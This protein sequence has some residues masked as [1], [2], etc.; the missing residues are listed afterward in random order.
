[1][2]SMDVETISKLC[3][4]LVHSKQ[5]IIFHSKN[6]NDLSELF[7]LMH[8]FSPIRK[9]IYCCKHAS[10]T[11]MNIAS[12]AKTCAEQHIDIEAVAYKEYTKVLGKSCDFLILDEISFLT[13]NA[14]SATAGTVSQGRAIV[15]MGE[16]TKQ[17]S[18]VS[19]APSLF[20]QRIFKFLAFC[21]FAFFLPSTGEQPFSENIIVDYVPNENSSK[22]QSNAAIRPDSGC[23]YINFGITNDQR[24]II[25]KSIDLAKRKEKTLHCIISER[26]RG[27]SALL[28]IM[29][30][31]MIVH[32]NG[33]IA[34][35]AAH[36]SQIQVLFEMA[37]KVLNK[38]EYTENTNFSIKYQK[39]GDKRYITQICMLQ[40]GNTAQ[41]TCNTSKFPVNTQFVVID[42]AASLDAESLKCFLEHRNILMA[43]T[44]GGYEGTGRILRKNLETM[45]T[46]NTKNTLVEYSQMC[47]AIRYSSNDAVEKWLDRMLFLTPQL[48]SFHQISSIS[49]CKLQ[50]VNKSLLFDCSEESENVLKSIMGIMGSAHYRNNPDDLQNYAELENSHFC[51]LL[52]EDDKNILAVAQLSFEGQINE[53]DTLSRT[54]NA[55]P[56]VLYENY[57][58][59]YFVETLGV[60]IVRIAV[61]P[62]YSSQ[63][64]GTLL[65]KN[66][67][68]AFKNSK[69][70]EAPTPYTQ[71]NGN[72]LLENASE[73][74]LPCV[75]WIGVSFGANG[76]L[77]RFW[78]KNDFIPVGIK[79]TTSKTTGEF[80]LVMLKAVGSNEE[81]QRTIEG[82]HTHFI[83][84]FTEL[85]NYSFKDLEPTVCLS[86]LHSFKTGHKKNEAA[87]FKQID[88]MR[89]ADFISGTG[90][91]AS[92]IDLLPHASRIFFMHTAQASLSITQQVLLISIGF[93]KKS[94]TETAELLALR[95]ST[96]T[97]VLADAFKK[98]LEITEQQ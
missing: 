27:K 8:E 98:I 46:N 66:L 84:R 83:D 77:L 90:S 54:G 38:L 10:L 95:Q 96:L 93:Q 25:Q 85:M 74:R 7:H 50:F 18:L 19:D 65:L 47:E 81:C 42:E 94:L 55:I 92:I 63:G 4:A 70:E 1:M 75:K 97:M 22:E 43:T 17:Q 34:V 13:A 64:L 56:W 33:S 87:N 30:A 9:V 12:I 24:Q 59:K 41:Y 88:K 15:F 28:G 86:L 91:A 61:H 11:K 16:N 80:S 68:L 21:P 72:L 36:V 3:A 51:V 52:S 60:R 31:Y 73:C 53:H 82:I 26:G 62:E 79:Q 23:I 89:I 32:T 48:A 29:I 76:Q 37:I 20:F 40:T 45:R 35:A 78:K 14:L 6:D 5:R 57:R 67:I 44:Q 49:G 2:A 69:H 39:Q 71:V 58:T